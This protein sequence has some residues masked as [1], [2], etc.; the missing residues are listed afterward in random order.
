MA[1]DADPDPTLC[2]S[3]GQ[4]RRKD[5]RTEAPVPQPPSGC[6]STQTFASHAV[7]AARQ[8][9]GSHGATLSHVSWNR[10]QSAAYRVWSFR[11]IAAFLHSPQQASSLKM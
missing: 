9:T 2:P 6:T 7:V 8:L 3:R 5:E 10:C 11:A 4:P 1:A